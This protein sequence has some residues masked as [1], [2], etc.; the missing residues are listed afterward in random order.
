MLALDAGHLWGDAAERSET[1]GS[2]VLQWIS[3]DLYLNLFLYGASYTFS[4]N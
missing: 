4:Y 2:P 1:L 3:F